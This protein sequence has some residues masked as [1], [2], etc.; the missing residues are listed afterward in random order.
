[1]KKIFLILLVLVVLAGC[2]AKEAEGI[3]LTREVAGITLGIADLNIGTFYDFRDN[4]ILVGGVMPVVS[5]KSLINGEIGALW[6][7][8]QNW[9]YLI[10]VSINVKELAKKLGMTYN[11]L[12]DVQ[13]GTF[14]AK[15]LE[16]KDVRSSYQYGLYSTLV[17][18][19]GN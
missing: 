4:D 1:M 5:W 12:G 11:L 14:M 7:E 3:D 8:T 2:K 13:V 9:S 16:L 10:G 15:E 19:F 6:N 17:W 18:Q